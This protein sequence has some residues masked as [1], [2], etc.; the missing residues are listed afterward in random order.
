[1]AGG[2]WWG[3]KPGGDGK[4]MDVT[5]EARVSRG[6]SKKEHTLLQGFPAAPHWGGTQSSRA[7]PPPQFRIHRNQTWPQHNSTAGNN[8][9]G[10]AENVLNSSQFC[11][12]LSYRARE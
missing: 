7:R 11:F 8:L 5:Q 10:Q 1:M 6:S 2:V 9:C 4:Q 12:F 3:C